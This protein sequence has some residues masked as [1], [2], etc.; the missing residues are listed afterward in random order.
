[1]SSHSPPDEA[2]V[3]HTHATPL[4]SKTTS[5]PCNPA[6]GLSEEAQ[7][8]ILSYIDLEAPAVTMSTHWSFCLVS[9]WWLDSGRRGLY[10]YPLWAPMPNKESFSSIR[11]TLTT[12]QDLASQV[13]SLERLADW[14]EEVAFAEP[15]TF[16]LARR[17]RAVA[18]TWQADMIY[19]CP[20][21]QHVQVSL[22]TGAVRLWDLV[23]GILALEE[24]LEL[25]V[26]ATPKF[27][28]N[29]P[30][31]SFFS[32]ALA[33]E[34]KARPTPLIL[35]QLRVDNLEW[36][37]QNLHDRHNWERLQARSYI[38]HTATICDSLDIF[39][40]IPSHPK[41]ALKVVIETK[42][43]H[44]DEHI[45]AELIARL[46]KSLQAFSLRCDLRC[47]DPAYDPDYNYE[48]GIDE[49]PP[50]FYPYDQIP[51]IPRSLF[52]SFPNLDYFFLDGLRGLNI[53]HLEA[54]AATSPNL[55]T[56]DLSSSV[57][58]TSELDTIRLVS[59][60]ATFTKLTHLH[61]GTLPLTPNEVELVDDAL[62]VVRTHCRGVA[63]G[64]GHCHY[65][66]CAYCG[67]LECRCPD[68]S[69]YY[70]SEEEYQMLYS[71]WD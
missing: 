56:L 1:M 62:E 18:A 61:L 14:T 49:Y 30:T 58:D 10:R 43:I 50:N 71:R 64:F 26:T 67:E 6:L 63:C 38:V 8:L 45:L 27:P 37:G 54:L 69:D 15:N 51:F 23:F 70:D 4:S 34:L 46:P 32:R 9:R 53:E 55:R 29:R 25:S 3:S 65:P 36:D 19:L 24:L 44:L 16:K 2:I 39:R 40:I 47:E 5:T 66:R 11:R 12:R 48:L 13:R 41:H 60:C 57:W 68:F 22:P 17:R 20:R 7:D 52:T 33:R 35:N 59:L 42:E 28:M 21:A 31:F